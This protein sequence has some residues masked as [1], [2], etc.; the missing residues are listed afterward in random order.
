MKFKKINTIYNEKIIIIGIIIILVVIVFIVIN[1]I[2]YNINLLTGEIKIVD[3]KSSFIE[4]FDANIVS[5]NKVYFNDDIIIGE[6]NEN[7]TLPVVHYEGVN[8]DIIINKIEFTHSN[9]DM[10]DIHVKILNADTLKIIQTITI[11]KSTIIQKTNSKNEYIIDKL[12][13]LNLE[14]NT[15]Y[16]L[17][18]LIN[19]VNKINNPIFMFKV[20]DGRFRFN[21]SL[22]EDGV[23]RDELNIKLYKNNNILDIPRNNN[24]DLEQF[25]KIKLVIVKPDFEIMAKI[26]TEKILKYNRRDFNNIIENFNNFSPINIIISITDIDNSNTNKH[27]IT[28]SYKLPDALA[29]CLSDK[30]QTD[31]FEKQGCILELFNLLPNH[32]YEL[33]LKLIYSQTD[34][35]SNIRHS[36]EFI[37]NI[38]ITNTNNSKNNDL[39][40]KIVLNGINIDFTK[41]IL[42]TLEKIETFNKYQNT[43]NDK[44]ATVENNISTLMKQYNL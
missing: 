41:D 26:A 13:P 29:F 20:G 22:I 40:S 33:K 17:S 21:N 8:D 10:K 34:N 25:N 27:N 35:I 32:T 30:T 9:K 38:N 24:I 4:Y 43:Q 5:I 2:E 39:L 28:P 37:Q 3:D 6:T 23:D 16:I 7:N 14:F 12:I 42:N 18:F 15:N 44:I 1:A 11:S 36:K 31:N 19:N